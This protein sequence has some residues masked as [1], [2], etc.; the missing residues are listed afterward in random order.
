[1]TE[2]EI[3]EKREAI[4]EGIAVSHAEEMFRDDFYGAYVTDGDRER[5]RLWA[6]RLIKELSSLGVVIADKDAGLP[7]PYNKIPDSWGIEEGVV[8][9]KTAQQDMLKAGYTKTH[10]L[11]EDVPAVEFRGL[12][13]DIQ[14]PDG[15][16]DFKGGFR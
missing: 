13:I 7:N 2:Q 16:Y 10:S 6:D 3:K 8:G 15:G 14:D 11:L 5:C 9:Y 1:M 12:D 4:R